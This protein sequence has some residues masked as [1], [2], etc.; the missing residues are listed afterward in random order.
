MKIE[1]LGRMA[2]TSE[3]EDEENYGISEAEIAL[4]E[5]QN[6]RKFP[7]AY[8]EF[9]FLGGKGANMIAEMNHAVYSYDNQDSYWAERQQMAREQLTADKFQ[10]DRDFWVFADYGS[11]QW[12]FFYFDEG[13]DPPVYFYC[14]YF[15]DAEGNEYP[16]IERLNDTFSGYIN[17]EIED[18]KKNGY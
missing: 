4:L 3:I 18:K 11:E 7:K 9:L 13:D 14:S 17:E 16:G 5:Q 12:H 1:F 10:I 2:D 8:Q 15:D 6:K